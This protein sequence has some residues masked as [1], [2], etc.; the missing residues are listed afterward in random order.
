MQGLDQL[1]DVGVIETVSAGLNEVGVGRVCAFD[2]QRVFGG[3]ER[4]CDRVVGVKQGLVR[5]VAVMSGG[6]RQVPLVVQR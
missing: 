1:G 6:A 5:I 2:E 4:G 3:V